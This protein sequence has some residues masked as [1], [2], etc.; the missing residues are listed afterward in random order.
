MTRFFL[1]EP[2]QMPKNYKA[3]SELTC[4]DLESFRRLRGFCSHD[5]RSKVGA[6]VGILQLLAENAS[7]S[8]MDQKMFQMAVGSA[9]EAL[10]DLDLVLSEMKLNFNL[11]WIYVESGE[12]PKNGIG[13]VERSILK[14]FRQQ[15]DLEENLMQYRPSVL[16]LDINIFTGDLSS[17]LSKVGP[18]LTKIFLLGSGAQPEL[19]GINSGLIDYIKT[20]DQKDKTKGEDKAK[21]AM[22]ELALNQWFKTRREARDQF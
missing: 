18:N 17:F 12:P 10:D 22:I 2:E 8:E 7:S 3:A 15:Q 20:S 13:L 1:V 11:V 21:W 4:Q 9:V 5:L 6:V 14:V 19:P 16:V